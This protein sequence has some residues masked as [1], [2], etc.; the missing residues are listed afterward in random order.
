MSCV[1]RDLRP[2]TAGLELFGGLCHGDDG[3]LKARFLS[4]PKSSHKM[5]VGERLKLARKQRGLTQ[6]QLAEKVSVTDGHISLIE[7]NR[8]EPS[9]PVLRELCA[10]LEIREPWLSGGEGPM[11]ERRS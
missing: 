9:L 2:R 4:T 11:E 6:E 8:A 10:V 3:N 5:S 7:K 1:E